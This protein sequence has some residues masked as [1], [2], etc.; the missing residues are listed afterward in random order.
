M[1]PAFSH[2]EKTKHVC[3][4]PC[5]VNLPL[6]SHALRFASQSSDHTGIFSV[7]V[8]SKPTVFRTELGYW[9]PRGFAANVLSSSMFYF[10]VAG[11]VIGGSLTPLATS[12]SDHPN[13]YRIAMMANLIGGGAL[14]LGSILLD[15]FVRDERRASSSVQFSQDR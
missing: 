13:G 6:G 15:F 5:A 9:H 11:L 7:D 12:D 3:V 14:V 2:H 4:T 10:G 1:V 8:G